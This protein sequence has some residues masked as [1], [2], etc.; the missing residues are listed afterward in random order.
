MTP[1]QVKIEAGDIVV[2][3]TI[4]NAATAEF[5]V[6][7]VAELDRIKNY[8]WPDQTGLPNRHRDALLAIERREQLL[9]RQITAMQT[10]IATA[11]DCLSGLENHLPGNNILFLEEARAKLTPHRPSGQ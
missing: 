8:L 2:A 5:I 1:P 10:A 3:D 9:K 11:L 4:R 6:A 7:S